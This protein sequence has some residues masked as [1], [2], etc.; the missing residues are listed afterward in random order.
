MAWDLG[1]LNA[2]CLAEKTMKNSWT[3]VAETNMIMIQILWLIWSIGSHVVWTQMRSLARSFADR[4]WLIETHTDPNWY[5]NRKI[6]SVLKV[7]SHGPS[8]ATCIHWVSATGKVLAS[9]RQVLL[10]E[11]SLATSCGEK[12][13]QAFLLASGAFQVR[14]AVWNTCMFQFWVKVGG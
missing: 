7:K 10:P 13:I 2:F 1:H 3:M 4:S 5:W 14:P 11:K 9:I 6:K 8:S 12:E